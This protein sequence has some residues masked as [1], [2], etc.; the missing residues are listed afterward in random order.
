MYN[1]TFNE[2]FKVMTDVEYYPVRVENEEDLETYMTDYNDKFHHKLNLHLD[3]RVNNS[4]KLKFPDNRFCQ[5]IFFYIIYLSQ[6][7]QIQLSNTIL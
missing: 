7:Q 2:I 5:G 4:Y 6:P 1:K 3:S